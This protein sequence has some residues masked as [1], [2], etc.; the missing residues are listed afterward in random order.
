MM[1]IGCAD[2]TVVCCA[3]MPVCLGRD[4]SLFEETLEGR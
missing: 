4:D 2:A 3:L 1:A